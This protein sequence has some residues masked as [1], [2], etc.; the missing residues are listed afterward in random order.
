[1]WISLTISLASVFRSHGLAEPKERFFSHYCTLKSKRR[2]WPLRSPITLEVWRILDL[3]RVWKSPKRALA[4]PGIFFLSFS[5][6]KSLFVM[7]RTERQEELQST[8]ACGETE[9]AFRSAVVSV[10]RMKHIWWTCNACK[11]DL[12]HAHM[13]KQIPGS[14]LW[15]A[16]QPPLKQRCPFSPRRKPKY[17]QS[18]HQIT[19]RLNQEWL[20]TEEFTGKMQSAGLMWEKTHLATFSAS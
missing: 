18:S 13:I 3:P 12:W 7:D 1:M 14:H 15:L 10:E 17:H 8:K 5:S 6:I 16:D 20:G 4:S 2:L 9:T 11:G 19:H